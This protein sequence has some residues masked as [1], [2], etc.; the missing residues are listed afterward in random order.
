M[1][2]VTS[3]LLLATISISS[4]TN[5]KP[6]IKD[7]KKLI[8][9]WSSKD[10]DG[11]FTETWW[12]VDD[13]LIAGKSLM[14]AGGDTLFMEELQLVQKNDTIYYI[15][16]VS[17]QNDGKEIPFVLKS[18]SE[19]MWIFT[20]YKHDFPQEIIY[21]FKDNDHL[22]ATVQG[23]ENGEFKKFSFQLTRKP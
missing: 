13:K 20:N 22:D 18:A 23:K 1:R 17:T 9:T 19:S 14:I 11:S 2:F 3:L 21:R 12:Q 5:N 7:F 10:A 16:S 4:C 15:P 6:E 8:G